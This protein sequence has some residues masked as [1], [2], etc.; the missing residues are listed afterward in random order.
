[1]KKL[2]FVTLVLFLISCNKDDYYKKE[3]IGNWEKIEKT[4]AE[5]MKE[6]GND[7][8][9]KLIDFRLVKSLNYSFLS[10]GKYIDRDTFFRSVKGEIYNNW[11]Q[12]YSGLESKYT[13][14]NKILKLYNSESKKCDEY[15]IVDLKNDT[16][17]LTLKGEDTLYLKRKKYEI[18][19]KDD[20][21]KIV[22]SSSGCYGSCPI[23]TTLIDKDGVVVFNGIEYNTIEGMYTAKMISNKFSE[24]VTS[25]QKANWKNLKPNYV[26]SHTDDERIILIFIKDNKII[27]TISDYGREAPEELRWAYEP[28]RYLYQQLKLVQIKQTKD[29]LDENTKLLFKLKKDKILY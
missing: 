17:S 6:H 28:L 19:C 1:M 27:K 11:E 16:L 24:I 3:I 10:N 14:E 21:D 9:V 7:T 5:R 26:A 29:T 25:F 23:S 12:Y 8:L 4:L 13:I 2:I 22:I 18:K 15:Q 20:F